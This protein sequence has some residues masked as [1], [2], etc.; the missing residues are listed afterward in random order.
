MS[1]DVDTQK[2]AHMYPDGGGTGP[3][4]S[5]K[6][7]DFRTDSAKWREHWRSTRETMTPTEAGSLVRIGRIL[8]GIDPEGKGRLARIL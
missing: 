5:D 1:G 2:V 4:R 7:V 8:R 3:C 6:D